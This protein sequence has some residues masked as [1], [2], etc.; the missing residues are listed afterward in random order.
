MTGGG[1]KWG[2][3]PPMGS[4]N[5]G[6]VTT[7]GLKGAVDHLHH[8][9]PHSTHGEGLQHKATDAIHHPIS[10]STYKGKMD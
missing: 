3:K 7:S 4:R 2:P 8:E 9:H 5:A 6:H 10:P 1:D